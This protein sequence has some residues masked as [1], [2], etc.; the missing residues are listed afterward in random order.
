MPRNDV[1]AFEL[2]ENIVNLIEEL[3]REQAGL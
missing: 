2:A 3:P 1:I